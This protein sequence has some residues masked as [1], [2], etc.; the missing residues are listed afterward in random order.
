[1]EQRVTASGMESTG[2]IDANRRPPTEADC[3][4]FGCVLAYHRYNG[5]MV[6]GWRQFEVNKLFTH[7]RPIPQPPKMYQELHSKRRRERRLP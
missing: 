2:W 6:T 4:V 5:A 3:D 7:W 1:M